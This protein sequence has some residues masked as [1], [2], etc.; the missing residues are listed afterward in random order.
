M[1]K[2]KSLVIS[3]IATAFP[4]IGLTGV[5][6][7]QVVAPPPG[8]TRFEGFLA[9]FDTLLNWLFTLLLILA[10]IYI[11]MAAFAYLT[12]GGEEEKIKKAHGKIIFAVVAIAVALLSK[13]I[14]FV[15]TQLLSSGGIF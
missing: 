3:V 9:V 1:K 13:G 8:I 5:A 7:G 6:F 10:V 4:G 2:I 12:A 14:Q 11:I 15:V